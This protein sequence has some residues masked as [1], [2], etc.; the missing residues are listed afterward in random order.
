MSGANAAEQSW[1]DHWSDD[2]RIWM[3]DRFSLNLV[4]CLSDNPDTNFRDLFLYCAQHTLGSHAR[5]VNADHYGNLY[6]TGPAEF[7]RYNSN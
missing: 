3:C 2:A 6:T 7:I 1:A 5:I 4:T